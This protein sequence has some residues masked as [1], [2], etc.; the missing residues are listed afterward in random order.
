M[1]Q[2]EKKIIDCH[3]HI[4]FNFPG[5]VKNAEGIGLRYSPEGLMRDLKENN[6]VKAVIMSTFSNDFVKKFVKENSKCFWAA[7]TINPLNYKVQDL[8]TLDTDIKNGYF[9]A[10]KLYPGYLKFYPADEICTP[11]YEIAM[12]YKIP[13]VFHSGDTSSSHALL[14]YA[15]PLKIDELAYKFPKL[16]I[17]I[18][19]LGNPWINDTKEVIAKNPNVY[20]DLSGLFPGKSFPYKEE[21]KQKLLEQIEDLIYYA[22]TEK[23]L[24]GTDYS[25]VS[26]K[27]YIEFIERLRIKEKDFDKIFYKNAL[28]LF[29]KP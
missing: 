22:G 10:I 7:A 20:S 26:H 24:F 25:L 4:H 3:I 15:H 11:I 19:H 9:K 5:S 29:G 16:R 28:K 1:K 12:E 8:E 17:I 13:V 23:L 27:E 14:K 2:G 21:L 6:I 18:A